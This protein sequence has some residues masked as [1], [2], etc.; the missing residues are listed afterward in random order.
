[1]NYVEKHGSAWVKKLSDN[2]QVK[3]IDVEKIGAIAQHFTHAETLYVQGFLQE[4]IS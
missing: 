2:K 1:M 4:Q 3:Y